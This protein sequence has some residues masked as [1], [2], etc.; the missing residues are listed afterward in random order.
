MRL[1]IETWC[2]HLALS[3]ALQRRQRQLFVSGNSHVL[4]A[5]Y[6]G[7]GHLS[8][9]LQDSIKMIKGAAFLLD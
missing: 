8:A 6:V 9:F 4:G 3:L 7:L 5:V 2:V 1:R